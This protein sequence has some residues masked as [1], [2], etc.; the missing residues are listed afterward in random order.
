MQYIGRFA[1]SPSGPL[2]FGSLIAA[3]A[4]YLC[5]KSVQGKWLLRIEDVDRF[6]I[7]E[8]SINSIIQTLESYGYQWD[9]AILYQSKRSE[10]YQD[11]LNS[12][13]DLTYPCSCSRKFLQKQAPTGMYGYTYLGYCREQMSNPDAAQFAIRLRTN[14]T[15]VYFDDGLQAS[16][17][18][19]IETEVGDFI[20]KRSDNMF[21]Y[22]L[23]VVVDDEYQQVTEVVRGSDLL[24]NTPRQ[25]YLQQCLGYQSPRYLHFPTAITSDGKKLSKHYHSA[26]V[27]AE[28]KR[29]TILKTL[30]FLGQKAP[31]IDQFSSLESI[32]DWAIKNWDRDKIPAQMTLPE[33]YPY[34]DK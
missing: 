12:L 31:F 1:P 6:R 20:I 30:N 8:N 28:Q 22:Q 2:H 18:Q 26:P 7:K 32:W 3:T 5:A 25:L 33:N 23:A 15:L 9:D 24:D 4:S 14:N 11:A 16:I 19:S 17:S 21:S 29:G 27:S 34:H 13:S 10:A